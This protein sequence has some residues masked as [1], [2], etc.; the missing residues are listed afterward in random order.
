MKRVFLRLLLLV[1]LSSAFYESCGIDTIDVAIK[2]APPFVIM[3]DSLGNFY[4]FSIDLIRAISR[5]MEPVPHLN[6]IYDSTLVAHLDRIEA[7]GADLGI[8][9][10]TITAK[11]ELSI[12]FSQPFFEDNLA[13]LVPRVSRG[14]LGFLTI[15]LFRFN[16]DFYELGGMIAGIG[17]YVLLCAILI[18]LI[19]RGR[20]LSSSWKG[21]A[22]GIWWTIV[23][24]S[25]VGYGDVV[26]RRGL[27]KFVGI[28]VVFSGIVIFGV[29]IATLSSMLT[30]NRLTNRI[31]SISDLRGK[32]VAVVEGSIAEEIARTQN[33]WVDA[34]PTIDSALV[35]L[36]ARRVAAVS[37]DA[38][39]LRYYLA[40]ELIDDD[41]FN[42]VDL[43]QYSYFYGITF[44][45]DSPLREPLTVSLLRI[46]EGPGSAIYRI[47]GK[48][49]GNLYGR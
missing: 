45:P 40:Q 43:D 14:I 23:T 44:P 5:E 42:L 32:S 17:L 48:W 12:D 37:H 22:Q 10:T 41:Q 18:W 30:L 47:G 34:V 35:L 21:I 6:F 27:G 3:G 39:L 15:D 24:M 7:G 33:I 31:E 11:R 46:Q 29:A 49:F 1:C 2:P 25:T 4:G 16:I 26:P 13:L 20:S 28:V 8:A 19:E 9:A 36:Q 38:S